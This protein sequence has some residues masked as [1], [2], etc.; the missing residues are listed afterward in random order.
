MFVNYRC[1]I[2]RVS[3]IIGQEKERRDKTGSNYFHISQ[4]FGWQ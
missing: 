2:K 3:K 4:T 1:H